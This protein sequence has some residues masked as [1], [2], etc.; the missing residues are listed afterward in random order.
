[1]VGAFALNQ[2]DGSREHDAIAGPQP[3][4]DALDVR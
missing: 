2:S 4:S 1:M 3:A